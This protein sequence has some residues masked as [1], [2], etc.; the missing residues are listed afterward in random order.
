VGTQCDLDLITPATLVVPGVDSLA[1]IMGF[2]CKEN[3]PL[4]ILTIETKAQSLYD[5]SGTLRDT[6]REMSLLPSNCIESIEC[7]L[8]RS[9]VQIDT[10][11]YTPDTLMTNLSRQLN[12]FY[13]EPGCNSSGTGGAVTTSTVINFV[14]ST[15]CGLCFTIVVPF[16]MY[17]P[18]NLASFLQTQMSANIP[19]IQVTWNLNDGQF[20]FSADQDFGL[21]LDVSTEELAYRLGF[22]P[23][24]YRNNRVYRSTL[25]F[26]FPTKGCCGTSIP[27]RHLSYVYNP[28][29]NGTQRKF[30]IELCKTRCIRNVGAIVDNGDGTVTITT[31]LQVAPVV[32]IAHGY[33]VLDVVE[34][35]VGGQTYELV[36]TR[37]DA[38][39]QFTVD[40][41]S[42][43]AATFVNQLVCICLGGVISTNVYFSCVDNNV[44][45]RTLG[46]TEC[47]ALW[48]AS[49]P[50]TWIPP[51][52]YMLDWPQYVL[53]EITDPDGATNNIHSWKLDDTHTDTHAK[54]LAKVILYPQFRLERGFP[55]NMSI[56]DLRIINRIRIR[57]LNSNHLLYKLHSRDWS[58]TL[59]FHAV[60][61]SVNPMCY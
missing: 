47:D 4:P 58:C 1:H 39:N 60:E 18:D 29:V 14:Y 27:D 48:N 8:C 13:F 6:S 22:Y 5:T 44:L 50:T 49:Q 59:L 26:Y 28:I 7:Y 38:Y 3:I 12:R 35:T 34:I 43:S 61:K 10:G 53:V 31:Q 11:N 40:L 33:Q 51:A 42:I 20:Q 36:V 57:I 52:C 16:G 55:F 15:N 21:E 17:N 23:I 37:I 2:G 19:S 46:Y 45:A 9:Q 30:I 25:P 54:V 24:C 56:P 41:G 32:N